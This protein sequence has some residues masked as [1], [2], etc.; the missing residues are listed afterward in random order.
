MSIN[1]RNADR[2]PWNGDAFARRSNHITQPDKSETRIRSSFR[3]S[4]IVSLGCTWRTWRSHTQWILAVRDLAIRPTRGCPAS[5][6]QLKRL[7]NDIAS[8]SHHVRCHPRDS[9]LARRG[10]LDCNSPVRERLARTIHPGV[11]V[12]RGRGK[13]GP[14]PSF[15]CTWSRLAILVHVPRTPLVPDRTSSGSCF[16]PA[17][18]LNPALTPAASSAG[19]KRRY[20]DVSAG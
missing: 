3:S 14:A 11:H 6:Q 7:G 20:P 8:L 1:G 12:G 19:P 2:G 9:E 18:P 13:R 17:S 16:P 4:G 5:V 15:R 10:P